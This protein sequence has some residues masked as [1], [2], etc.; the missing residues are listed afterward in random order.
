MTQRKDTN[1]KIKKAN[2]KDVPLI[3]SLIKELAEYEKLTHEVVA[4]EKDLRR[5]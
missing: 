3:L 2:S 5:N 1:L 4:N